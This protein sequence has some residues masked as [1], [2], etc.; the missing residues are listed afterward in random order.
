MPI[1]AK[2]GTGT[3][4]TWLG[5]FSAKVIDNITPFSQEVG[6]IDVNSMETG[7]FAESIP[8]DFIQ[9]GEFSTTIEYQADATPPALREVDTLTIDPKGLGAGH[10]IRGSG[11]FKKFSPTIGL[12]QKN[13]AEISWK[14]NGQS[15]AT[16]QS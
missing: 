3:T 16:Q 2:T 11:Y 4:C 13:T 10:L 9:L 1:T 7:D 15:F 6:D 12:N 5:G 14:W 8:E